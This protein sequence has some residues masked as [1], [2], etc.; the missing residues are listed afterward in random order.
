MR[1]NCRK[2]TVERHDIFEASTMTPAP[3]TSTGELFSF[4]EKFFDD[5]IG[6]FRA[7]L[8]ICLTPDAKGHRGDSPQR[9]AVA[10]HWDR[11]Y[12]PPSSG[13]RQLARVLRVRKYV[14][15][16]DDCAV[17]YRPTGEVRTLWLPSARMGM[18]QGLGR[19]IVGRGHAEAIAVVEVDNTEH[20]LT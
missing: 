3:F 2:R 17:Q 16:M 6:P 10:K 19:E 1:T 15:D 14:L 12:C 5:R 20:S 7:G 18:S 13:Q 8:A 4:A 11:E 9:L